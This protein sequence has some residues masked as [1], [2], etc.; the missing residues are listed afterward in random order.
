MNE[1]FIF[2]FRVLSF[3]LLGLGLVWIYISMPAV[4]SSTASNAPSPRESF[5]AP[6][7]SLQTLEGDTIQLSQLKGK[8]IVLNLWATWCP[9]C[10]AE[11]PALQKVHQMYSDQPV[12]ILTANM[13]HQ[14]DPN[15]IVRFKTEKGLTFPILLDHQGELAEKYAIRSLPTTFFIDANGIIRKVIQ[16]GPL[17]EALLI[18]Q[19]E[20]MLKEKP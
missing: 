15:Q 3:I 18:A 11:M 16:G 9:P 7:F 10:Q 4:G 12:I 2:K 8:I 6:N 1:N 19:V 17:P 13:T 20:K 5:S 14:D